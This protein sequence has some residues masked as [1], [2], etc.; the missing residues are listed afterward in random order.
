MDEL[1]IIVGPTAVGKTE[2]ALALAERIN[3]EIISADSM[4]VYRGM[5]IGTAKPSPDERARIPHHLLDVADPREE[6]SAG[7]FLRLAEDA[8]ADIRRRGKVPLV[9]GGTG[10]YV[11]ALTEGLFDGPKA[12]WPLRDSLMEKERSEG[13]GTLYKMLKEADPDAASR[14][15][16]SDLRRIIRA[17]EVYRKE[18]RPISERH[19]EHRAASGGRPVRIAGLT[20]DRAELYRRIEMRVDTMMEAG[21]IEE[22]KTLKEMGC[23]RGMVSMQALGYKQVLARLDGEYTLDEAVGLIKRDTKRYAKR[24]FT[25]FNA[26]KRVRWVDL[27]GSSEAT[28]TLRGLEKALEI[29]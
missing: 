23:T 27:S 1:L 12:D 28:E 6:F 26:E 15:H 13:E 20:R 3:A 22:V 18:G 9:V 24:Q 4:Q 16:P 11:R 25:W 5:D 19:Q 2:L 10:L 17:L 8:I 7:D 29:F 21:F 14:I